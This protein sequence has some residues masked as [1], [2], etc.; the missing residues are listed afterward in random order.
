MQQ[1]M[2]LGAD[3]V[4]EAQSLCLP[5]LYWSQSSTSSLGKWL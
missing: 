2:E 4:L 5:Q 1:D 3:W